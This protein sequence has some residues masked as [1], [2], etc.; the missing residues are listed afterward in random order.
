[1]TGETLELEQDMSRKKLLMVATLPPPV[2]GANIMNRYVTESPGLRELFQ[3]QVFRLQYAS[4]IEDLGKMT[5][6][7]IPVIVKHFINLLMVLYRYR[8]DAVYFVPMVRGLAFYRDCFFV[9]LF[10]IF[11][12]KTIYHLHGKGIRDEIRS[13]VSLIVYRWFFRGALVITLSDLLFPDIS[14]L[15]ERGSVYILPNA[16]GL[17]HEEVREGRHGG[18]DAPLQV[19]F[20]SN[21]MSTKGPLVLL[22]AC[23]DL[24]GRDVPFQ[25]RF[26]GGDRLDLTGEEFQQAIGERE[27]GDRVS[28]LGPVYGA[29]K[30]ALYGSSDV[31]VLPTTNDCFP[32]VIIEAMAHGLPVI[33]TDEGAVPEM[34]VHDVTGFIVEKNNPAALADRIEELARDRSLCERMSAEARKRFREKFT[35][36]A[37]EKNLFGIFLDISGLID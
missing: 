1:M 34:V 19:L 13:P 14:P 12:V 3:V 11:K 26:A 30:D 15:V 9:I 31:F 20:V 35:I 17:D 2:H 28:Y 4:S 37:F 8:P 18:G 27:L 24:K 16:I 25:A 33:S 10:R 23:M 32:L 29:G 5:L 7:K 6:K 22:D 36:E 21:L